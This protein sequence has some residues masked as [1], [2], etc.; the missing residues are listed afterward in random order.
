MA[1]VTEITVKDALGTNREVATLTETNAKLTTLDTKVAE[2][3][4]KLTTLNDTKVTETNTKLTDTNT[5]LDT[6]IA[7]FP[8]AGPAALGQGT[9][10][11]SSRVVIASD[12]STIAVAPQMASGGNISVATNATGS[13]YNAFSS[14]ACKQLTIVNDTGFDIEFQQGGSGVAIPIF[15][16]SSFTIFGI[17]NVNSIG[18]RRKDTSNTPVT[19][20]ARWE[21]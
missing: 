11:Q 6:L 1:Q 13:T 4:T 14:Q 3:N 19:V 10:A 5:K 17:S 21:S 18:V 9:M 7:K 8:A 2:T 15:D 16:G 20:K 12:Q